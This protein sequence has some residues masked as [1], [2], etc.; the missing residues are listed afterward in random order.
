MVV[1]ENCDVVVVVVWD[2]DNK[3]KVPLKN[4]KVAVVF[5]CF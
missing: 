5:L 2:E 3:H 1:G 4:K